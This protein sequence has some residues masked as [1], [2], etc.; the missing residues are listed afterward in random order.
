MV[1]NL[2]AE[3]LLFGPRHV[4]R[5]ATQN[6][7]LTLVQIFLPRWNQYSEIRVVHGVFERL[8][9]CIVGNTINPR[10]LAHTSLSQYEDSEVSFGCR[11][12]W[13]QR[14]EKFITQIIM[15]IKHYPRLIGGNWVQFSCNTSAK[16]WHKCKVVKRVQITNSMCALS[17]FRWYR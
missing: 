12:L 15:C 17:K 11:C 9:L 10:G 6:W 4:E 16:V 5:I 13:V 3:I 1:L 2:H 7:A 8:M 14:Q